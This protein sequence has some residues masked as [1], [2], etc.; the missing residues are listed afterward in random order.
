VKG[1][2]QFNAQIPVLDFLY[3]VRIK[4]FHGHK[5]FLPVQM[6]VIG[7]ANVPMVRLVDVPH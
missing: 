1:Q 6:E 4:L 7:P 3:S 2:G 5:A